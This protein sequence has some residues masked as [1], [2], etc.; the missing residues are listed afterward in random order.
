MPNI[1]TCAFARSSLSLQF[2]F[3]RSHSSATSPIVFSAASVIHPMKAR[4]NR[5]AG[6]HCERKN[7]RTFC[8]FRYEALTE[9]A[10][11]IGSVCQS[12]GF[13]VSFRGS[14]RHPA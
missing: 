1:E 13:M 2:E 11:V 7:R 3:L 6:P 9:V 8:V 14:R 12:N 10:R 4:S 5:K